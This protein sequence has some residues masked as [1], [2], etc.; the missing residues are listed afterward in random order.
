MN[1]EEAL[2]RVTGILDEGRIPYMVIGGVAN[3][4]WGLARTTTDLDITVDV[5][6]TGIE[7]FLPLA[8]RC[9]LPLLGEAVVF[10]EERRVLPIRT[11][12]GTRVDFI[13]ATLPF[14]FEAIRRASTVRM[15]DTEFRVCTAEDLIILKAASERPRDHDDIVGVLRRQKNRLDL[16]DVDSVVEALAKDLS[17]PEIAERYEKAKR[18]AGLG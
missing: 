8:R 9:G 14:E 18:A 4:V 17:E 7:S 3:L 2:E 13:L 11:P 5:E 15:A 1:L 12:D 10:A 6:D 16:T